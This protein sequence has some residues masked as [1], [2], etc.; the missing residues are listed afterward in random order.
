M[1]CLTCLALLSSLIWNTTPNPSNKTAGGKKFFFSRTIKLPVGK[2]SPVG[3]DFDTWSALTHQADI[4]AFESQALEQATARDPACDNVE[5]GI[6][7]SGVFELFRMT[8][9]AA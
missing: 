1:R 3:A 8:T 5:G 2:N 4:P 6:G 9:L 7:E